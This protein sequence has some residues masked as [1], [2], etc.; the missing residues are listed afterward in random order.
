MARGGYYFNNNQKKALQ[1]E[2]EITEL[3]E[4]NGDKYKRPVAA[5]ITFTTAEGRDRCIKHMESTNSFLL[6]TPIHD[7]SKAGFKLFDERQ[8]VHAT[9]EPSNIIWENIDV[10]RK[11]RN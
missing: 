1:M 2:D 11:K 8:E 7:K 9:K 10:G 6:E 5:F 3:I 4:K